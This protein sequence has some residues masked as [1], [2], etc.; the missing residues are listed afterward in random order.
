MSGAKLFNQSTED[1]T[2]PSP[3]AGILTP[4]QTVVVNASA[5]ALANFG[6]QGGSP[7]TFQ[8]TD[9][10][11]GYTGPYTSGP[12][13]GSLLSDGTVPGAGHF[14]DGSDGTVVFDGVATVLGLAPSTGIYTLTR[15]IYPA[16]MTVALAA[17][18]ITG[19]FRIFVR[20]VL[21]VNG[22]I[23]NNGGAGAAPTAGVAV[24][25][26]T[27]GGSFAG[28]L[29]HAAG[30]GSPGTAATTSIGGAGGAGGAGTGGAGAG[31]AGTVTAPSA[32]QGGPPHALPFATM[33]QA[34][35]N[36]GLTLLKGGAG[37]GAGGDDGTGAGGGGGGGGG[38]VMVA[39]YSLQFGASGVV[40]ALGGAG[41]AGGS[42]G[43]TN[44]GGGGGG[45]GGGLILVYHVTNLVA[46]NTLVTGGVAGA[47]Q[48][49]GAAGAAGIVGN[50][51]QIAA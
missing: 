7:S 16:N 1:F 25:A 24:T 28:G 17:T 49:T 47:A 19:S 46:A 3:L 40:E 37:G 5:A 50:I 10:G 12:Y 6:I 34:L 23:E 43:G 27:L 32:A 14:G 31:I 30:A 45:G 35:G 15:D 39:A 11:S 21:T 8:V 9:L 38:V 4:G 33:G 44:C 2:L 18:I 20:G 51:F 42:S 13:Q 48:G 41:H 29:G 22:T 36:G 26:Q